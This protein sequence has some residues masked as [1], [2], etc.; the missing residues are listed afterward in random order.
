MCFCVI[1]IIIFCLDSTVQSYGRDHLKQV[2][3]QTLARDLVSRYAAVRLHVARLLFLSKWRVC[4]QFDMWR[5]CFSLSLFYNEENLYFCICHFIRSDKCMNGYLGIT[6]QWIDDADQIVNRPAA[7]RYVPK[8]DAGHSIEK[9]YLETMYELKE[10]A[11]L[12]AAEANKVVCL[13]NLFLFFVSQQR[14]IR[15]VLETG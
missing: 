10:L 1:I 9:I 15:I 11:A 2:S 4:L 8:G 12:V 5:Y 7:L 13:I 6:M 3:R 14:Y